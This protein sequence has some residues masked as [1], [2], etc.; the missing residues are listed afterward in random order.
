MA[1]TS[2]KQD[3][4]MAIV[5]IWYPKVRDTKGIKTHSGNFN[6]I[7]QI[8][9]RFFTNVGHA[10]LTLDGCEPNNYLSW[11]PN[12]GHTSY[13]TPTYEQDLTLER[14]PPTFRVNLDCLNEENISSWWNRVKLD[15][16]PIPY[17][18]RW[19]P[20]DTKWTLSNNNCSHMVLMAME[21]GGAEKFASMFRWNAEMVT[22]PQLHAYALRVKASAALKK[23]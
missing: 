9:D 5:N 17:R 14:G 3:T 6:S 7:E 2:I 23:V 8:A 18:A 16:I 11:W 10:S 22:P 21:L 19:F 1:Q 20:A 12:E 15:A 4:Q 13:W